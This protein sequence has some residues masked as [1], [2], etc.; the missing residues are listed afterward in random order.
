MEKNPVPIYA[1]NLILQLTCKPLHHNILKVFVVPNYRKLR[2]YKYC[3]SNPICVA[4]NAALI[5]VVCIAAIYLPPLCG[6]IFPYY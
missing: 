1:H 2:L 6:L 4:A 5:S 3:K